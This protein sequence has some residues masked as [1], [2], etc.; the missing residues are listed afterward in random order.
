M[1]KEELLSIGIT[2]E[3]GRIIFKFIAEALAQALEDFA[4]N[5]AEQNIRQTKSDLN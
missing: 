2:E 5:A 4:S 3:Q 1:T